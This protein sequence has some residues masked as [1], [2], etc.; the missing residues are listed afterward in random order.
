MRT[1]APV[2]WL[3]SASG[4][5]S[6]PPA[7]RRG[8]LRRRPECVVAATS[9]MDSTPER[10][11]RTPLPRAAAEGSDPATAGQHEVEAR[12]VGIGELR[13]GPGGGVGSE[14]ATANRVVA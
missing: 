5:G 12:V 14:L 13:E 3:G 8:S 2:S 4:R 9:R 10:Q 6:E 7:S 11:R 1:T